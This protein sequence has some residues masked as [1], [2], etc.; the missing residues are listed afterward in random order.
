MKD[1]GYR[2][3]KLLK[4]DNEPYIDIN[5]LKK[6]MNTWKYPLHFIDFE[7]TA[8]ALPFNKG[9]VPYEGVAFQFSHHTV[10]KNGNIEHKGQYISD[11]QGFFP[12]FEFVRELKKQLDKDDGTIFRYATHENTYLRKI[13]QQLQESNETDKDELC[14]WVDTITEYKI[15]K[16]KIAGNRNMVDMCALVVKYYYNPLTGGSNSLKYVLPATIETSDYLRTKYSEKIY[17]KNK[18]IKSLNFDEM[19]WIQYNENGKTKNPYDLLPGIFNKETDDKLDRLFIEDV[20]NQ[21]GAAMTAYAKM[22]FS[23][24]TEEER[25]K[26]KISLLKYCELDTFAM[27]LIWEYWKEITK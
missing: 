16:D 14:K 20:I 26:L 19:S 13:S 18:Q 25:E 24:M 12:N 27:V 22:Q 4:K 23:M 2:F 21:G 15:E 8:T 7:T 3:R 10:D 17:G 5:G 1:S 6:E 9:L 11:K